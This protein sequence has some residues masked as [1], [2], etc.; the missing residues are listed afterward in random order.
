VAA[1]VFLRLNDR[2]ISS[3]E[4]E[5]V[6]LTVGVAAAKLTKADAAVFLRSH[7]KRA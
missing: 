4:D 6:E 2:D 3:T 1:L 7:G 5:L